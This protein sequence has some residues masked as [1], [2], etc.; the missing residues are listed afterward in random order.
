[1]IIKAYK[2]ANEL[3]DNFFNLESEGDI[4]GWMTFNDSKNCALLLV[5]EILELP[6]FWHSKELEKNNPDEY[7]EEGTV[8]FWEEVK[9][10]IENTQYE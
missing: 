2:K 7:E 5:N 9:R 3:M 6:V 8:E 4:G 10:Q 1:M